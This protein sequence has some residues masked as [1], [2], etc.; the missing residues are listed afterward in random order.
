MADEADAC[1]GYY[2]LEAKAVQVNTADALARRAVPTGLCY[3]CEG[4]IDQP[5]L[6]CDAA[7]EKDHA[8]FKARSAQAR[9]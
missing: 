4:E 9:E 1:A 8:W 5:K 2:E 7:C 3:N 6:Y